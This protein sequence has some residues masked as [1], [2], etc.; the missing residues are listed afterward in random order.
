V[1]IS[2]PRI[3]AWNSD[4]LPIYEPGLTEVV[5]ECRGRNLFFSTNVEAKIL[6]CDIIFVSVNTPTKK[7]GMGKGRA[8]DLK[9]WEMVGRTIAKVST[10]DKI[11]VEKSTV[12][13]RTAAALDRVLNGAGGS[14]ARFV[15]LSNPEFLAEGTAIKDLTAPDRIL[16]GGPQNKAGLDSLELL[17]DVYA[18]WVPRAICQVYDPQVQRA[19]ALLEFEQHGLTVS[20]KQFVSCLSPEDAVLDAHAIV[21]LTEWDC[22]K[23]YD[24]QKFFKLMVKPAFIFDGRNLLNHRELENMGFEVHAIGKSLGSQQKVSK[25]ESCNSLLYTTT[26]EKVII[27]DRE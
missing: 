4:K 18:N 21:V 19:D 16:I 17:A 10:K 1:D 9:F 24:Y 6:E 2:A 23:H 14:A 7:Q 27:E 11:V 15:I 20:E 3:Q 26:P 5:E 22:F 25:A 12:P 13:V 8:A